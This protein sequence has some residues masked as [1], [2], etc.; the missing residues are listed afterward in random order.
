MLARL[1]YSF[2]LLFLSGSNLH[3]DD[4]VFDACPF[5]FFF[6]ETSLSCGLQGQDVEGKWNKLQSL[7]WIDIIFF[8]DL[9][10]SVFTTFLPRC[11]LC[12]SSGFLSQPQIDLA[13]R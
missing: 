9:Y 2:K 5:F 13:S 12:V 10:M 3:V 1:A 4:D 8:L 11:M 7:S 6:I